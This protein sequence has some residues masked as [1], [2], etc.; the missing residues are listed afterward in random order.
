LNWFSWTLFEI[1]TFLIN[2]VYIHND[3]K[4][5]DEFFLTFVFKFN[6]ILV[7]ESSLQPSLELLMHD[8]YLYRNMI[9]VVKLH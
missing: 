2:N 5:L 3:V 9:H 6:L 8:K 1:I 4:A 7:C